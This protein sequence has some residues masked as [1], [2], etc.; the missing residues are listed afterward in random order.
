MKLYLARA[1][2]GRQKKDVVKEAELDFKFFGSAGFDVLCPVL[3][4]KVKNETGIVQATKQQMDI[5]WKRDKEMIREAHIVLDMSPLAPSEGVKHELGYARYC[6]WKPIVRIFPPGKL[7]LRAS[8]AFYEDDYICDSH[9]EAI[10][11]IFR[12]HG[13]L[14][15]RFKWRFKM[16]NRCLLRWLQ[17]QVREFK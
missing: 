17:H 5:F 12:V 10:E 13:T 9:I 2:T 4:E 14:F 1:M 16:L 3:A 11:Y 15:K 8:V 6:L 7:P